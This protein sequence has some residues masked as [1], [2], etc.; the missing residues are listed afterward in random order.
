M[1][2]RAGGRDIWTSPA[3]DRRRSVAAPDAGRRARFGRFGL[4]ARGVARRA[5]H[6]VR[7]RPRQRRRAARIWRATRA[8]RAAAWDPPAPVAELA[9]DS[10]DFAPAV[11]ATETTM[12][13][14]PTARMRAAPSAA[15]T[16]TSTRRRAPER[17]AAWGWPAAVAGHR[18][19]RRRIRSVRGAG[20]AG[21]V[22]HVDAVGDGRHLLVV[23]PLARGA[24]CGARRRSTISTRTH[25]TRTPRCHPTSAR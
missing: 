24:V 1:S 12:F 22:L 16:S 5:A 19:Q 15:P 17:G 3:R 14:A 4:G 6:L 13:S 20:R 10:V 25:T 11:D 2:T 9:S 8:S 18:Q 21:R 7:E 23:A